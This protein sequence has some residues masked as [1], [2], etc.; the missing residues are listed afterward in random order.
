[1]ATIVDVA[2]HAG[3]SIA[4]VSRVLSRPDVVASTTRRRVLQA[5]ASLGYATNSAGKHLRT[6]RSGKLLVIVPDISNSFYARV[7]QSIDE[8]AQEAGFAVVLGE[9]RRDPSRVERYAGMLRRREAE[10]LI[11]LGYGLPEGVLTVSDEMGPAAP[12]VSGCEASG[13][14]V[15]SVHIDNHAAGV[16]AIEHLYA[17][18]HRR[19]SVITG[20]QDSGLSAERLRGATARATAGGLERL[21]TV[22]PGDFTM[23]SGERAAECLL[24]EPNRPTGLFCFNDQMALGAMAVARRRGLA[25]PDALSIVGIDDIAFARYS[26]PPLTTVAQPARAMGKE[27]VR[28]LLGIISGRAVMPVSVIL[29][30]HLVVRGSTGPV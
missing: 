12:I 23:A 27:A 14:T 15:P 8:T 9:T 11:A 1:V 5:V 13:G 3:V 26:Y 21:L 19:I 4:T 28:V 20:P 22:H 30:H 2:K 24:S 10:G 16:D 29:P 17:L 18:G 6:Q 7:L 25:V